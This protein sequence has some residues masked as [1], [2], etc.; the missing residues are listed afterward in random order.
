M[1]LLIDP[2]R[3]KKKQI[4][5]LFLGISAS[6]GVVFFI[7]FLIPRSEPGN[8][9]ILGLSA[10]RVF[11]GIIFMGLL[12]I[13]IG[14]ML[15][16]IMKLGPWQKDFERNVTGLFSDH[17]TMVMVILYAV[18][19][20]TGAFLLLVIPPIIRPLNFL[21][22]VSGRLD[23]FLGWIF[24]ADLLLIIMLRLIAAE[25][26]NNDR[27]ITRLDEILTCVGLF[28]VVF[29]L[30]THIAALIGWIN[31][32]KY[33]YWNLLAEQFLKGKLYLEL[34][35]YTHDLTLHNGR[36]YVP[37]P[38]LPAIVMM[39]LAYLLGGENI[40]TSYLS[41]AFSAFNGVLVFLILKQLAQ[42]K[43]INLSENG[44][45]WLVAVFLFGTPHL[46]VGIN[47]GAWFVSQILTVM[48]LAIAI[49]AALRVSS[50]WVIGLLIAGSVL[51]RPNSLM[52]WPFVFAITM[53]IFKETQGRVDL[54][55]AFLW[56]IKTIVPIV[57][58]IVGL[59]VYNYLRFEN[60]TDFGYLAINGD[61]EIVQNAKTYGLFSPHFILT[62]LQVML[63]KMP[64]IH[65]GTP[66]PIIPKGA[67]W[68]INPTTTGMSIFLATPPLL[69]L[70]RR[71]PKQWWI[72]GAW[73]A[74]LF[75]VVML[76]F[77]SN[78]GAS[79]FGYRYI[80]DF[81]VP[82]MT[83]LAVGMGKRVPWH[84]MVLVLASIVINIY[85]A[86]WLM[87]G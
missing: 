57:I 64:R 40:S 26:L 65:W 72:L 69:Y 10:S 66:W 47:G 87:N 85:G 54:K 73:A 56:S 8:Q 63:F 25:T 61:Q 18:L 28:L 52:T 31:K 46:W 41:M 23:S 51:A 16:A 79:Q 70:F 83:I 35:Q 32:T 48:F 1:P 9:L 33:S 82:I 84:F 36:W 4:T 80:L 20:L 11:I 34:P 71:Y 81:L 24:F 14:A 43:W 15:L 30:Y 67:Q 53:Q 49:Y 19:I 44:M 22:Q 6:V 12:L 7:M 62:N 13:N 50:P 58:A 59:L 78:T 74:I 21:E 45:F 39:P 42:R 60:F 86:Y 55:Q 37:M 5:A 2:F 76:S 38:P 29:V 27:V 3:M 68:P 77:Y 17:H 75:N